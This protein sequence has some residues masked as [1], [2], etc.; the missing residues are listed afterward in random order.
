M[1]LWTLLGLA[2]ACAVGIVWF[3]ERWLRQREDRQTSPWVGLRALIAADPAIPPRVIYRESDG[4]ERLTEWQLRK[5]R[6]DA[7]RKRA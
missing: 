1:K 3:L 2:L 7:K 4:S 5:L 6:Q